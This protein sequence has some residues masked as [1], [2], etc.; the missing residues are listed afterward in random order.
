[1]KCSSFVA[2][3]LMILLAGV[4]SA[5]EVDLASE[6]VAVT[7]TQVISHAGQKFDFPDDFAGKRVVIGFQFTGCVQICPVSNAVLAAVDAQLQGPE[8]D[9]VRLIS[10]TL[11]PLGDSPE[12]LAA[13]AQDLAASR[14]WL[15]LTGDIDAIDRLNGELGVVRGADQNH[16]AFLLLGDPKDMRFTRIF[17]APQVPSAD[18]I[19]GALRRLDTAR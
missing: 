12:K 3:G 16:E 18:D 14:K 5:V 9:D 8:F 7:R 1:M 11:D 15:W 6:P 2:A 17:I 4:A 10:L 13:H 19:L